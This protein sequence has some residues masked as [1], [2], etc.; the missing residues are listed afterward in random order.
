M[1]SFFNPESRVMQMLSFAG[2]LALLNLLTLL[3][4]LP[5]LTAGPAASALFASVR[6]LLKGQG[7]GTL[8]TYWAHWKTDFFKAEL[9]SLPVLLLLP[10][11]GFDYYLMYQQKDVRM[12][13]AVL[14]T[15]FLVMLIGSALSAHLLF[16]NF[17][18]QIR[19]LW[20]DGIRLFLGRAPLI[21]PVLLL[22]AIPWMLLFL[23]PEWFVKLFVIFLLFGFSG[24]V[25]LL[26]ALLHSTIQ[27]LGELS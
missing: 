5:V 2:D 7:G 9:L 10:L 15:L 6:D 23:A 13:D 12:I 22:L 27:R 11:C 4:S 19:K 24:P 8:Q 20:M 25:C 17:A 16:A 14:L 18:G 1:R 26:S 3:F 21:L